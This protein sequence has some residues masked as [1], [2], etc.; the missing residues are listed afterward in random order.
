MPESVGSAPDPSSAQ[1]PARQPAAPGTLA[2]L[3]AERL[4]TSGL[5]EDSKAVLLT[6]FQ[7]D[8]PVR[9]RMP[10][11]YLQ[12][13]TVSGFRGIGRTARLPLTPGPGLTLVTGRN[14]SGKSSFAEATEIALTGDNARWRGRSDIWRRSWRNLHHGQEPQIALELRIDGDQESATVLRTWHGGDVADSAAELDRP[15]HDLVPL[16][17]LGWQ[18]DLATYRPFLSYSELGQVIGGKPS[19]MYDAVASI[20]GLEQLAAADKRLR[21]LARE[22]DA[23]AKEAKAELPALLALLEN[24]DDPRAQAA[25]SALDGRRPDLARA[26]ELAAGTGAAGESLL[27]DLRRRS[28]LAG[29]DTEAVATAVARLRESIAAAEDLRGTSAQ[30]ALQRAELL[31]RALAHHRAHPDL[32]TCP[33]CGGAARL[34]ED[35]AL[36]AAEQERLLRAEAEQALT[37]RRE[38]HA[39]GQAVRDLAVP[40]PGWLPPEIAAAWDDWL[41]CR[42]VSEPAA[43]ASVAENAARTAAD[44]ARVTRQEAA[45]RLA[46]QDDAWRDAARALAAW[47]G[48]AH[49][50]ERAIP[51]LARVKAAQ[52]WLK[53]AHDEIRAERMR[54]IAEDA[55]RIWSN[56][57]Q[58]SNVALG[59]VRLSG[60]ATQ[61]K[62]ALD[63]TVDDIDAPALGVMSQGE[64]HALA[65][66][67]FL[68]RTFLP[69][70]PF[71]FLVIDDPVQSM[72]P[73]KVDGLARV[74]ALLAEHRQVVVFTH[75]TRLPQALKYLRLPATV[76]TVDRREHSAVRVRSGDD[77]VKQALYDAKALAKTRDLPGDVV[78]R[79]LPGLCRTALEAAFLEPARRRLLGTGLPHDEIERRI[80]KAHKLT[81]LASL[82]LYG[83]TDRVGEAMTDLTRAYGQQATDHI[84]WCN[85]GSH[86]AVPVDDV[87]EIIRRTADL[88][89]AVRSL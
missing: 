79:V 58:Q 81:E 4:A 59:P 36:D 12:S 32:G 3:I 19:E 28:T 17:D 83:E 41:R 78:A 31:A 9:G 80:A 54:P 89:K 6:A 63:V 42:T 47:L 38:L 26:A 22:Y 29:P 69:E 15:G 18:E 85:R 33:V 71:R 65:L 20:L 44:A 7:D 72:D 62:V 14:G 34:D 57:R 11:A 46:D 76:L 49:A 88:A 77:P 48:K 74:L 39:A 53:G 86:E 37:A 45:V 25:R 43:L 21:D 30:D 51:S 52:K 50:A 2:L 75:D 66:S 56:L 10:G 1:Q 13:V 67:L 24:T 84:R 70:N 87:E 64:L 82:A 55:Q 8:G 35:W 61:R 27:F 23:P 40:P 73:A 5:D 16:P 68:P 60:S